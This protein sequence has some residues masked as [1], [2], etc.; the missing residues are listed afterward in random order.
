M[1]ERGAKIVGSVTA[2]HTG[3][4][5]ESP[6]RYAVEPFA[7]PRCSD[8]PTPHSAFTREWLRNQDLAYGSTIVEPNVAELFV[9]ENEKAAKKLE[10]FAWTFKECFEGRRSVLSYTFLRQVVDM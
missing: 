5:D 9:F 3:L 10:V 2:L 7:E 8:A 1:A 4:G 6:S